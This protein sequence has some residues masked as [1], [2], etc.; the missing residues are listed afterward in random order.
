MVKIQVYAPEAGLARG[1]PLARSSYRHSVVTMWRTHSCV[2]RRH[3]C[4]RPVPT[5]CPYPTSV[6]RGVST[7]HARVRAP[8]HRAGCEKCGLACPASLQPFAP[9][10]LETAAAATAYLAVLLLLPSLAPAQSMLLRQ[11]WAIQS[12]ADVRASG[13]VLST[14]S[15]QPNG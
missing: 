5:D 6:S 11:G 10:F 8:L 1:V 2:P 7:R 15:F 12:S 4:R 9:R 14:S 3:S 13:A